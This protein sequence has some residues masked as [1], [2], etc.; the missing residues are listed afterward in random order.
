MILFFLI[1]LLWEVAKVFIPMLFGACLYF[2]SVFRISR[3]QKSCF[4]NPSSSKAERDALEMTSVLCKKFEK[5]GKRFKTIDTVELEKHGIYIDDINRRL[6][7]FLRLCMFAGYEVVIRPMKD[8]EPGRDS[9]ANPEGSAKYL[10]DLHRDY[11]NR[12]RYR[13]F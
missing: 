8:H 10:R 11:V 12:I 3:L 13:L 6:D 9:E 4:T 7:N 5:P 2:F 1:Y